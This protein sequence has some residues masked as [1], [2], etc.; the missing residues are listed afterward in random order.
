MPAVLLR[1][2]I[3]SFKNA[4][5]EK[6]ED[7]YGLVRELV[8]ALVLVGAMIGI[9]LFAVNGLQTF[10]KFEDIIPGM[11]G[12]VIGLT[13]LFLFILLQFS[14]FMGAIGKFYTSS[15]LEFYLAL[16]ISNWRFLGARTIAV[17]FQSGWMLLLMMLP[18]LLAIQT[19][20]QL[21]I[22]FLVVGCAL[23]IPFILIPCL[24]SVVIATLLVNIIPAARIKEFF[25]IILSLMS[26][27][28]Y[29]AG[30]TLS[31]DMSTLQAQEDTDKA[32]QVIE[33]LDDPTPTWL[34]HHQYKDVVV[35]F[36]E[37]RLVKATTPSLTLFGL[38]SILTLVCYFLL[39]NLHFRGW[40]MANSN[41]QQ[42]GSDRK[43][44]ASLIRTFF[45]VN[46]Q[47]RA[48]LY[49]DF[50][51]VLRD[52]AQS[53]QLLML[54]LLTLIYLYNFKSLKNA[55]HLNPETADWWRAILGCSNILLSGCVVSAIATRFAY[56]AI[57]M[58]GKSW[59]L[60]RFTP[61]SIKGLVS[62]K[63]LVWLLPM[64]VV[65]VTLMISGAMAIH[66]RPEAV[67][68]SAFVSLALA[69][70]I[71]GMAVGIGGIYAKF[72]WDNSNQISSGV[73]SLIFMASSFALLFAN[74]ILAAPIIALTEV[75][76]L[77]TSLGEKNYIIV[78][79]LLIFLI[80]LLNFT[81]AAKSIAAGAISL[82]ERE[83]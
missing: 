20:Y 50:R 36:M 58:E 41:I 73:G 55:G 54:L 1:P 23:L 11:S 68:L 78:S 34:P 43:R 76:L 70:G 16:P 28:F 30:R 38:T 2:A 29:L 80:Y 22:W 5:L 18:C 12:K 14:S 67:I 27:L 3:L 24:F 53:M 15:D 33:K 83:D 9:Y 7:T 39:N 35:S 71:I 26:I 72:D 61:L 74:E 65:G 32:L 31:E 8:V 60:V 49:K 48:L 37:N 82:E 66:L 79:F 52:T 75:E 25:A 56:P 13:L 77:R 62:R 81:V 44:F 42:G 45:P 4:V 21:D 64:T 10:L 47:F 57:S 40:S 59:C 19:V 63:F 17:A 69:V 6:R 46:P 51:L